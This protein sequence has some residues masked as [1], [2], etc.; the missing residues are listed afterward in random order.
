MVKL[1]VFAVLLFAVAVMFTSA[2]PVADPSANAMAEP[3]ALAAAMA[4]PEALADAIAEAMADPLLS[5]KHKLEK[6]RAVVP[7]LLIELILAL[8]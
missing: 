2:S 6:N 7:K 4:D 3:E 5:K 8:L 1:V